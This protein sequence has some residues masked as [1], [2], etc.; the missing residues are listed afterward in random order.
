[1]IALLETD[2]PVRLGFLHK[3][4]LEA[5]MHPFVFAVSGYPGV[6]SSRLM[7]P[8]GEADMALRLIGEVEAE[9]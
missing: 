7:V 9:L 1:M 8:E 4:L 5:D 6:Q 3:L 2:D